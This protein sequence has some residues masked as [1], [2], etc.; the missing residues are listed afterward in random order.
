MAA[1][2]SHCLSTQ[3]ITGKDRR[4]RFCGALTAV[5][6][7][8]LIIVGSRGRGGVGL[9]AGTAMV[10]TGRMAL[11]A[12]TSMV[13]NGRMALR[14]GTGQVTTGR[15]VIR[16]GAGKVTTGR[17]ALRIGAGIVTTGRMALRTGAGKVATG[18]M[19]LRT[20][21]G[22]VTTG[23]IALHTRTGVVTSEIPGAFVKFSCDR[24]QKSD[25]LFAIH[26]S[27]VEAL[28]EDFRKV[29]PSFCMCDLA[30]WICL[31]WSPYPRLCRSAVARSSRCSA[32]SS[33][34]SPICQQIF[35]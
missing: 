10:T 1:R 6:E 35:P 23:R 24:I 30:C 20:G 31:S 33:G 27:A 12:V 34:R 25:F 8:R 4:R 28:S 32:R 15:M 17:I 3:K 11:R 26:Y 18:R 13:T 7:A 14:T 5:A 16:T 2:I 19:A 21:T 22:M 29:R 9:R